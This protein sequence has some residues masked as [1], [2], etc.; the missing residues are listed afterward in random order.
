MVSFKYLAK[1]LKQVLAK[2]RQHHLRYPAADLT[3]SQESVGE[4]SLCHSLQLTFFSS[5]D[6]ANELSSFDRCHL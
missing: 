3:F 1:E 2:N 6:E 5:L 4:T